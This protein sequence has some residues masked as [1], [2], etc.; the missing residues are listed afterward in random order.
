MADRP[1]AAPAGPSGTTPVGTT[2]VWDPLVRA[3]H[4]LLACSVALAWFTRE[5]GGRWHEWLGY[6]ALAVV[7]LRLVWGFTGPRHARFTRFVRGPSATLDYARQVIAR[8]E[9]RHVGH[10]PLGAWMIVALLATVALAGASGWLYTADAY[11]GIAWVEETHAF[12]SDALLVLVAV[13][14]CGALFASLRH[15]ENLVAAMWHGRKRV[16]G[17]GDVD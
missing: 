10:N 6:V 5:G 11:W 1:A 16:P 14:V 9:P 3:G 12:F 7:A 13:H 15:G 2:R 8:R 4:W 17:P